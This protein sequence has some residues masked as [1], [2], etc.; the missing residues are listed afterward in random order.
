MFCDKEFQEEISTGK[1]SSDKLDKF[2]CVA[3]AGIAAE[4]LCFPKAEGGKT[5]VIQLDLL[6]RV[7]FWLHLSMP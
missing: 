1:L 3:L 2:C 6:L 5:D 4:T 7:R